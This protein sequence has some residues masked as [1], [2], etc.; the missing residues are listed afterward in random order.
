MARFFKS[1]NLGQSLVEILVAIGISAIILPALYLGLLS[2]R[3]GKFQSLQYTQANILLS[4]T[5]EAIRVYREADWTTFAVNG[6]YHPEVS[7]TTWILAPGAETTS[8]E[9]MRSVVISDVYRDSLNHI[10]STGGNIDPSTKRVVTTVSWT[11]PL[12][13]SIT[14]TAYFSRYLDN[15]VFLQTSGADFSSGTLLSTAVTTTSGGEVTLSPNTKGRWCEPQLAPVTIDLPGGPPIALT[16]V[17]GHAYVAVGNNDQAGTDAFVHVNIGNSDPPSFSIHGKIQGYRTYAVF[18]E[19]DWGY[20]ATSNNSREIVI[21]NL[22]QYDDVPNKIYH[23]EGWFNTPSNSTDAQTIFVMGNRGYLTSNNYLYVF[24]LTSKVGSRN[25][26]GSRIQ[27]ANSGDTAG[28]IFV[29]TIGGQ[30]FAFVAI[31]GS[32]VEELK[33]LN[34]TNNNNPNLWRVV[35]SINIEPNN[36]ST[37]ESGQAVFVNA[38]GDRAYVSSVND[39][40]F[41]EF[42]V[43]DTGNKTSPSLLGG[44]ATNPP[45]TNGGGYEAGGMNPEQSQVVSLVEN[46]AI[47]VGTDATGD[48]VNSEEYQVLD[49]GNEASPVRCGGIQFDQGIYGVAGVKETDGDAYA[50]LI[51][52]DSGNELKIVQGGPDGNYVES[53]TYESA[54]FDPGSSVAYNRF[55]SS[56]TTPPNTTLLYQVAAADPVSDSC[57]GAVYNYVGPDGTGST[58]FEPVGDP[59]PLDNTGAGYENP[60]RC[61]RVKAYLTT[62]DYNTTPVI[63]DIVVNYSP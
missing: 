53:G 34:V 5:Q 19:P 63:S 13:G 54:V 4:Q 12:S 42:F 28:E 7:G 41:K 29:R 2:S 1:F 11:T 47:L 6:T 36:C 23:I 43:I 33:I 26:V 32:T 16:A 61:F 60:A 30:T 50:Y 48:A 9:F 35:G 21:I 57:T 31:K 56:S 52:G 3:Q 51:T 17:E 8:D 59:I 55:S 37:L 38:E 22:N 39:T 27:F 62:T 58:F 15:S 46:R 10:V 45:C 14:D 18:G 20:I 40:T 49:L 44:F 25:Q 24:D